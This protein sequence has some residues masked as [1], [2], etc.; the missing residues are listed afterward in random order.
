RSG[1]YERRGKSNRVVDRSEARRHL[2][3]LVA[4]QADETAQARARL[5]TAHPTRLADL[6]EL[7]PAAFG[8]FLRLLGDALAARHPSRATVTT[9]TADG[10]LRI[11]LTALDDG[12][13]AEVR[14]PE[15]VFRGADHLVEIIDL[16]ADEVQERSA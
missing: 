1:S 3:A 15:G 16:M 8:L 5:A 9:T 6:G 7:D 11:R 13:T 2:A 10:T 4:R 14:T 12:T